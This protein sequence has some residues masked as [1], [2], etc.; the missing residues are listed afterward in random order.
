MSVTAFVCVLSSPGLHEVW[1]N[2]NGTMLL[3]QIVSPSGLPK[4][5]KNRQI[6]KSPQR[7]VVTIVDL[8]T[9]SIA[10]VSSNF[11]YRK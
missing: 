4:V 11:S 3:S 9:M 6:A 8:I 1:K 5:D 7:H 2:M 10:P